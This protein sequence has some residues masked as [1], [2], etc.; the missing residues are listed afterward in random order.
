MTS[1]DFSKRL[2]VSVLINIVGEDKIREY[3]EEDEYYVFY[4]YYS[5]RTSAIRIPLVEVQVDMPPKKVRSKNPLESLLFNELSFLDFFFEL[6]L[7]CELKPN[8][9]IRKL[10]GFEEDV[11]TSDKDAE[12]LLDT[13]WNLFYK[14]EDGIRGYFTRNSERESMENYL[15]E[16]L[17]SLSFKTIKKLWYDANTAINLYDH[18]MKQIFPVIDDDLTKDY[19]KKWGMNNQTL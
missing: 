1:V 15:W 6:S 18:N 19:M 16:F 4:L 17:S 13:F 10:F 5:V 11:K 8:E 7:Y 3:L 14:E 9:E 2:D 12:D